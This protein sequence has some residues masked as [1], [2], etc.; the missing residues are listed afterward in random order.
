MPLPLILGALAVISGVGGVGAG[1]HGGVKM[2][3]ASDTSKSAKMRHEANVER[4][5][6]SNNAANQ[7]M[8]T[9]GTLELGILKDFESFSD[10][11]EKIQN[12]PEFK[13]Y[14]R[15][16]VTL[17][18]FEPG[19]IREAAVGAGVVLGGLGGAAAGTAGGFAAAGA[20]TSAVMALGAA[21]T[22]TAISSLSG[23]AATN[24]TLAAIGGGALEAGG[25]GIALGT[26]I[27]GGMTLGV[28]LLVGG[29]IFNATGSKLSDKADE[30]WRQMKEAE[31][32]IDKACKYLDG[33]TKTAG[34]YTAIL[35]KAKL[36]YDEL[37]QPLNNLVTVEGKTNWRRFKASE[38]RNMENL[39]LLVGL[40]YKMCQVQLVIKQ[41]ED[42]EETLV[43]F[44]GARQAEQEAEQILKE[45][46]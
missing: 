15:K 12:R 32:K 20:T 27:L 24:A 9:L 40:L 22:G 17:P 30:A 10:M 28:G 19:K 33:L 14:D 8:D 5:H 39:V 3:E 44:E 21:S 34:D 26:S 38:K 29:F 31:E 45:V 1:I 16:G 37:F 41:S 23:A 42:D 4:L 25:G 43:N 6:K 2:K 36:R 18:R 7:T 11:I 35:Q 13:A 46:A